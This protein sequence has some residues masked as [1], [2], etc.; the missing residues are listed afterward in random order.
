M[1]PVR[2]GEDS[3]LGMPW[4]YF[5]SHENVFLEKSAFFLHLKRVELY[6]YTEIA[7]EEDI[8]IT[9]YSIHYTKL[10]DSKA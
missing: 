4:N 8:V 6:A 5:Y 2:L 10:Y 9:S 3:A 7:V 1:A